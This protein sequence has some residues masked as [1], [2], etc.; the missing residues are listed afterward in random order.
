M[1]MDLFNPFTEL[2]LFSKAL[3]M[4]PT[5]S[6]TIGALRPTGAHLGHGLDLGHWRGKKEGGR[7]PGIERYTTSPKGLGQ[8]PFKKGLYPTGNSNIP[9]GAKRGKRL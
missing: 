1:A 3:P 5:S 6:T 9:D 7:K 8:G 4:E 2:D